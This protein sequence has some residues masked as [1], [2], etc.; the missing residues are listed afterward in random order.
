MGRHS[1]SKIK[2]VAGSL[3]Q[4]TRP[5]W[6]AT[7][8]AARAAPAFEISIH[9]PRMGRDAFTYSRKTSFSG[10]QSTRPV[11][12]ATILFL[13][14]ARRPENFNPRAPYGARHSPPNIIMRA[15]GISIHAPRMGR[16]K[17]PRARLL[18]VREFQST[19]PVWGATLPSAAT[20]SPSGDFNP[21][22]PYGARRGY[23]FFVVERD[24][25]Q[26]TRPVWGATD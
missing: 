11:W 24:G 12:G 1:F 9:A 15:N 20:V 25:F 22:A 5:V 19:R 6:G 4:S 18:Y 17:L 2:T 21:R 7:A 3:F 8:G 13:R 14:H 23:D 26:S 16:D 10:F